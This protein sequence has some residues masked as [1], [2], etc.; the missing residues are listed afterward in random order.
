MPAA[1]PAAFIMYHF[2]PWLAPPLAFLF[3]FLISPCFNK[4]FK[5]IALMQNKDPPHGFRFIS[6]CM[7]IL[8][9]PFYTFLLS[10]NPHQMKQNERMM[11]IKSRHL[12]LQC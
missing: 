4:H 2:G 10:T 9:N 7:L 11:A 8:P 5:N 6:F 1:P 3:L 12:T